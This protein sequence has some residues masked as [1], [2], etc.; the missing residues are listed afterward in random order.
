MQS[1]TAVDERSIHNVAM[2]ILNVGAAQFGAAMAQNR[3]SQSR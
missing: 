2:Q 3:Q 1:I